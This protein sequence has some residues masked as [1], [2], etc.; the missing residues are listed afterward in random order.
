MPLTKHNV[1][2]GRGWL[3]GSPDRNR[4]LGPRFVALY[5]LVAVFE[6]IAL[7]HYYRLDDGS[8]SERSRI[9]LD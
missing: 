6:I 4:L 2:T 9:A 7:S 3:C 5:T 1:F 8:L